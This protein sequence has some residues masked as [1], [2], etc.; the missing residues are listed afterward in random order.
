MAH[1]EN[2]ELLKTLHACIAAC[3]HC[4]TACLD[5]E[6]VKMLSKCIKQDIDCA[7][8]CGLTAA[9][10]ARGSEFSKKILNLCAEICDTCAD[11]CEKHTNMEHCQECAKACRACAKACRE[12]A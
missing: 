3:N 10:V 8:M 9:Y 5:E 6:D 11:E 1:K 12:A 4:A 2:K 7:E